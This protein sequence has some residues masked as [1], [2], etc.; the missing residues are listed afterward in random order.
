MIDCSSKHALLAYSDSLRAELFKHKNISVINAQ[1]G[2]IDT[3]V[4][5]NALTGGGLKNN[6][7]DDD[8]RNGFSSYYVAQVI[9]DSILNKESEVLI[10]ILLHR[11]G[12]WLRFFC[13]NLFFAIM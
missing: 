3:N 2:Y 8:H 4:S 10:A 7:N 5:I 9:I 6:Q 11:A 1:P 13:P 12:I